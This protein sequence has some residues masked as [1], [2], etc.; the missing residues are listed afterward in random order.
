[1]EQ[2]VALI[3]GGSSGIGLSLVKMFVEKNYRV[4]FTYNSNQQQA[5]KIESENCIAVK[6]SADNGYDYIEQLVANIMSE[7]NRIDVLV[8]NLGKTDDKLMA[9]MK[10]DSF[11]D[12]L[13]V[14][15]VTCFNFSKAVVKHMSKQKHGAIINVSSIV[16]LT[17]NIGQVN[18]CASK[19]G[20][21]G[22]TKAMAKEYGRKNILINA[23]APGFI[24][25]QMTD[26]LSAEVQSKMK[27]KIA[28]QRFGEV[29]EIAKLVY[30]LADNNT[31]ITGQTIAIDGGMI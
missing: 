9:R 6:Y 18:Y 8:N 19:A 10:Q 24:K 4:Y 27:E 1:M 11:D 30:F 12:C 2:K 3:T 15:L 22:L 7:C 13:N 26:V 14:N 29:E 20:M 25:T 17:G 31:Y 28:L 23:I 21:I 5:Q 16:A